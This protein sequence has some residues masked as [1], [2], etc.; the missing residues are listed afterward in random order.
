[1]SV[2]EIPALVTA[3]TALV[4]A[5]AQLITALRSK[6]AI[7]GNSA[8]LDVIHA[9][10]NGALQAQVDKVIELAATQATPLELQRR[11]KS[12]SDRAPGAG[13]TPGLA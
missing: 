13:D 6:S 8:K 11:F 4:V 7:D 3:V 5:I 9:V 12:A 1:M 10:T 2:G